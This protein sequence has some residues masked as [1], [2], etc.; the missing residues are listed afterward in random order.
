MEGILNECE[1]EGSREKV[2]E[3][4]MCVCV[5]LCCGCYRRDGNGYSLKER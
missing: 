1:Q 2:D 3:M 5:D 4:E